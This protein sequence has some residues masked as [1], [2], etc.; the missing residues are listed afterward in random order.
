[1]R[2]FWLITLPLFLI[3]QITKGLAYWKLE[4]PVPVIPGFFTFELAFNTGAAFG[5][6]KDNNLFFIIISIIATLIIGWL[7]IAGKFDQPRLMWVAGWLMLAGVL[8]NLTDR[9]WNGAV[10]DFLLFYVGS[11]AWPNFNIA[12][13]C[14]CVAVGL[15]FVSSFQVE[16]MERKKKA[17]ESEAAAAENKPEA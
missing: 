3:D 14:I 9:I 17:A 8:G 16:I 2:G 10:I 7:L 6:L 12:D 13:S 15:I 4:E 1:M 5:M 11:Y